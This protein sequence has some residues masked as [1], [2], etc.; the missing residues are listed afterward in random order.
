MPTFHCP[1]LPKRMAPFLA[2]ACVC[3]LL[4]FSAHAQKGVT[5]SPD[6]PLFGAPISASEQVSA[7]VRVSE[8]GAGPVIEAPSLAQEKKTPAAQVWVL[9]PGRLI[10][11]E[12][13]AWAQ[14]TRATDMPWSFSWKVD[15]GWTVP[16]QSQFEGTF[17]QAAEAVIRT[18][19]EQGK[20]VRAEIWE[21]NRIFEVLHVDAR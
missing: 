3:A 20:P 11:E 19:F 8:Q 10:Q 12:L 21:G 18:L 16:A 13:Q 1:S 7:P 14:M 6:K 4:S 2:T 17:D 9:R 15:R 5:L